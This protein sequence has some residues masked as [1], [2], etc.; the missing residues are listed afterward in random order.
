[1]CIRDRPEQAH[2]QHH[3]GKGTAIVHASF[4]SQ[5]KT[6]LIMIARVA[7]LHVGGQYGI[8]RGDDGAEQDA[9]AER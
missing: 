3:K 5:G 9:G 2:A 8:G 6:Q 1:M 4:A 7:N